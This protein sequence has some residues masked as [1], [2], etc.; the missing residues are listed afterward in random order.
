MDKKRT[1]NTIITI[2]VIVWLTVFHYESTR[3]YWL[4]SI[5]KTK[6]MKVKFL[7]PPAGWIMFYKHDVNFANVKDLS[8]DHLIQHQHD[9]Y[10]LWSVTSGLLLP[11]LVGWGI[12]HPLGAFMK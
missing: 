10:D 6:L 2:F 9:H 5:F 4:E 7:F 8:N 11:M 12:G 1:R 3:G